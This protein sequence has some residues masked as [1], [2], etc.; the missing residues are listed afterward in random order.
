MKL[1]V[2]LLLR[3]AGVVR[4]PRD[5]K[6]IDIRMAEEPFDKNEYQEEFDYTSWYGGPQSG[7][8]EG[9]YGYN[10]VF[11][12]R[13][14]GK[15]Y[16]VVE[17]EINYKNCSS[18]ETNEE[19]ELWPKYYYLV[20]RREKDYADC[21]KEEKRKEEA[22]SLLLQ[23]QGS[24]LAVL[25]LQKL[26]EG[27]LDVDVREEKLSYG[28]FLKRY[29]GLKPLYQDWGWAY[30]HTTKEREIWL[31]CG[32]WQRVSPAVDTGYN[33]VITGEENGESI[34]EFISRN[35]S[36]IEEMLILT[37]YYED[38]PSNPVVIERYGVQRVVL[39]S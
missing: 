29:R 26:E 11:R 13:L 21:A 30:G 2:F 33:G 8:P 3:K 4:R 36:S 15:Q 9:E 25:L 28:E 27:E 32:E 38:E 1:L 34:E 18:F 23:L 22:K 12:T 10:T 14:F 7:G 31:L 35:N 20:F 17:Q 19:E 24:E 16:I 5:L 37:H 6:E 39:S